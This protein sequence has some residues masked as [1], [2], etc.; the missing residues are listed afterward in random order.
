M[1]AENLFVVVTVHVLAKH[2][3]ELRAL[4]NPGATDEEI[5]SDAIINGLVDLR[6]RASVKA[7]EDKA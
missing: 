3:D 7:E 6:W 4:I 1:S 5:I 2:L